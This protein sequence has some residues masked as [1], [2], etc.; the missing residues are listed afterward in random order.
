MLKDTYL[1][2]SIMLHF[3]DM[4]NPMYPVN[5]TEIPL[6][7]IQQLYNIQI[8]KICLDFSCQHPQSETMDDTN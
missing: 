8:M 6:N 4:F 5:H 2:V 3:L 1:Q 7:I